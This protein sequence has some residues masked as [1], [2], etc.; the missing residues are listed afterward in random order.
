[1][2]DEDDGG[3]TWMEAR[4]VKDMWIQTFMGNGCQKDDQKHVSGDALYFYQ[5]LKEDGG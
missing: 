5:D 4:W 2:A 1:M 3:F